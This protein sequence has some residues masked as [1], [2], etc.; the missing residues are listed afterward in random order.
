MIFKG[1]EVRALDERQ[2]RVGD[3]LGYQARMRFLDHVIGSRHDERWN[4]QRGKLGWIDMRLVDH[5]AKQFELVFVIRQ[6][7]LLVLLI[8]FTT[9]LIGQPFWKQVAAIEDEAFY[10]RGVSQREQY[11]HIRAIGEPQDVSTAITR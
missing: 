8:N 6:D 5:Q 10:A 9:R 1:D 4:A 3:A 11:G 2:L 7:S